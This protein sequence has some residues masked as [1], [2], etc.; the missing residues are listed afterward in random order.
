MSCNLTVSWPAALICVSDR[1]LTNLVSRKISTNRSTKMTIFGCAD[2]HGVIVY[3]GIGLDDSGLTP[4]EWVLALAEKKLFDLPI[5]DVI[6]GIKQDLE[7]RLRTLRS[8]YGASRTRHTFI[9]AAWEQGSP[10]V[11]GISNY[12]RVDQPGEEAKGSANVSLS[13]S[14][15][16]QRPQIRINATGAY[17]FRRDLQAIRDAIKTGAP[18]NRVKALSVKAVKDIAYGKS[19]AKGAVGASCQWTFLSPNRDETWFGLDVVGGSIAQE[20]PNLINIAAQVP[21]G[22]TFSSR[23]GGPGLIIK[24]TY[25]GLG[26]RAK[27]ASYDPVQGRAIFSEL[28]CGICQ[29]PLPASHRVCEVCSYEQTSNKSKKRPPRG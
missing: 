5:A 4:S 16:M 14:P 17:P 13:T 11:H 20:T 22:G 29:T 19:R 15:P 2:A 10:V 3:N 9:V 21:L 8:K 12:E 18:I 1:R 24:D 6:E 7:D 26:E 27:I 23:I 28:L 25:A